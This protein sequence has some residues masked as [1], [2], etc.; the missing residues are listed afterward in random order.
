S[1]DSESSFNGSHRP[2][3]PERSSISNYK[4]IAGRRQV[5][6]MMV[7]VMLTYFICLL[8]LRCM[9][10]W[11]LFA[12]D[13]DFTTLG[14]EVYLNLINSSRILMYFNSACNPIIYGLLSSNFRAAFKQSFR[15]CRISSKDRWKYN[16]A[17]YN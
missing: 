9:Q 2:R 4:V 7:A 15:N 5:I 14:Q 12:S 1:V 6:K 8:P 11:A 17:H 10:V 3:L 16:T 13:S